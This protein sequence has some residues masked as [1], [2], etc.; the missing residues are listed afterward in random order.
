MKT[1]KLDFKTDFAALNSAYVFLCFTW[2]SSKDS[3][4]VNWANSQHLDEILTDYRAEACLYRYGRYAY[5]MFKRQH[6]PDT[7]RLRQKIASKEEYT[8]IK[9]DI[10]EATETVETNKVVITG[11]WLYQLLFNALANSTSDRL[12]Y[13]NLNGGLIYFSFGKTRSKTLIAHEI[14]LNE[15]SW[16]LTAKAVTYQTKSDIYFEEKNKA[17]KQKKLAKPGYQFH[18][19]TLKRVNDDNQQNWKDIYIKAGRSGAKAT[20]DALSI[21]DHK[22]FLKSRMGILYSLYNRFNERYKDLV[23]ASWHERYYDSSLKD[24]FRLLNNDR[25]F[26]RLVNSMQVRIL[27]KIGNDDS[28]MLVKDMQAVLAALGIK[29]ALGKRESQGAHHLCLVKPKSSY[30]KNEEDPYRHD[31]RYITQHITDEKYQEC[32]NSDQVINNQ[33]NK[34]SGK[35]RA[36][37]LKNLL[38]ELWIKQGIINERIDLF[39]HEKFALEGIWVF[40]II[41]D[42]V[43]Y[44]LQVDTNGRLNYFCHDPLDLFPSHNYSEAIGVIIEANKPYQHKKTSAIEAFIISPNHDVNII[45]SE[46]ESV[47]PD[48]NR[49]ESELKQNEA[50]LPEYY[51]IGSNIATLLKDLT[52]VKDDKKC[53]DFID[54]LN[55]QTQPLDKNKLSRL[56]KNHYH[57]ST[58]KYKDIRKSLLQQDIVL[59][60]S[61]ANDNLFDKMGDLFTI[62]AGSVNSIDN[63]SIAWYSVGYYHTSFQ[64]SLPHMVHLRM[65]KSLQG[66]N[67]YQDILP[68]LDVDFVRYNNPTVLPFPIKY[69]REMIKIQN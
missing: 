52:D 17:Q 45:L 31:E 23:I 35:Q 19:N 62:R 50:S 47:L 6:Q 66:K 64:Q 53:N 28:Q 61:K 67:I 54:E 40:G 44:M 38:K 1:N 9:V 11:A 20:S 49:I 48:L 42:K 46:D 60:F 24:R 4:K 22:S 33:D 36:V 63:K 30:A 68:L 15:H 58:N 5:A 16:A 57:T 59:S 26:L 3:G 43:Y 65:I 27:D 41:V 12:A 29:S 32:L 18:L 21:K 10:A 55:E 37:V 13:H 7:E 34:K 8:H 25:Q 39:D 56:I 51:R 69:L 14:V 2:Q